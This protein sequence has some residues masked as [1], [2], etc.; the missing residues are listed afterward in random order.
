MKVRTPTPQT[1]AATPTF[2]RDTFS[3]AKNLETN[4]L[5]KFKYKILNTEA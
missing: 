4:Q 3:G 1:S 5:Q 2:S